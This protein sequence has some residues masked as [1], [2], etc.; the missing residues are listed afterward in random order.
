[1]IQGNARQRYTA[2]AVRYGLLILGAAI[3]ILPFI[4][5]L[6][7]SAKPHTLLLEYPPKLIPDEPTVDNYVQAWSA[8]NFGLYFLNST[9][10]AV[11]TTF[12]TVLLSAMMAYSFAR[13]RY[14][15]RSVLFGAVILGLTIPT[16]LLII[17][18]FLLAKDLGLLNS[19]PGLIPFYVGTQLAFSTFLLRAFFERI[20]LEL[21]EAM[22]IDGAG[23][24]RRFWS[25][26]LPLA[27]PA[28]ATSAIFTFLGSW[29]EFVWALTVINDVAQRTLPI[30][31]ALFQ[32]QH[33]TSWGL[34]FAG[35]VIAVVPVIIVYIVFQRQI[36]SGLTSGALKS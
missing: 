20:P 31:L 23:P 11:A 19:L 1:M 25:L 3:L 6:S 7:T 32:G 26:A 35:S 29:D 36:V 5:M 13:F 22:I 21:D 8:N 2:G 16:M 24:W 34:V 30:G 27:K 4:Y 15:G 12:C 33:A 9:L 18:Q 10:V 17:P 14:R 28:L